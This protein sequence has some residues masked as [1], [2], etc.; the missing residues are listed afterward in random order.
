MQKNASLLA[1]VAVHTAENEPSEVGDAAEVD[2]RGGAPR[3]G[4]GADDNEEGPRGDAEP[5]ARNWMSNFRRLVLGCI[6]SYDSEQRRIFLHFSRSTRFAFF[7]TFGIPSG[8]KHNEKPP[9][10]S[11][12]TSLFEA[13]PGRT[14]P[15]RQT[16]K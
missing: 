13:E 15:R 10:K 5:L 7:C 6:D 8:K 4:G 9:G 14:I 2:H 3:R 16:N 1:I 11:R 12:R